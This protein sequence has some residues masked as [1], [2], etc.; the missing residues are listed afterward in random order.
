MLQVRCQFCGHLNILDLPPK[1][2]Q[3]KLKIPWLIVFENAIC[4]KC[5]R[6]FGNAL[7]EERTSKNQEIRGVCR[8]VAGVVA[9][10]FQTEEE[11]RK[12]FFRYFEQ[13]HFQELPRGTQER[14]KS[15]LLRRK[16]LWGSLNEKE[17][18]W[19]ITDYE[20][21]FEYDSGQ[22]LKRLQKRI[23]ELSCE[24]IEMWMK[25]K[26]SKEQKEKHG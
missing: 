3:N 14:L 8:L 5:G 25:T 26:P 12:A 13:R 20:T 7:E 4:E 2:N 15:V 6:R 1:S 16:K 24:D 11:T 10:A 21:C 23:L 17:P 9:G 18:P 22:I 19:W